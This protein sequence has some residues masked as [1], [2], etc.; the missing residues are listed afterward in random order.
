MNWNRLIDMWAEADAAGRSYSVGRSED[1]SDNLTGSLLELVDSSPTRG[2]ALY[3]EPGVSGVV[4]VVDGSKHAPPPM[5]LRSIG[6]PGGPWAVRATGLDTDT[7]TDTD[8]EETP[9][10][11]CTRLDRRS[12]CHIVELAGETGI[13]EDVGSIGRNVGHRSWRTTRGRPTPRVRTHDV[14]GGAFFPGRTDLWS[15]SS[16]TPHHNMF[17]DDYR[18]YMHWS[19]EQDRSGDCN[20]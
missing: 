12:S 5:S 10:R 18:D 15:W 17:S 16:S 19:D 2:V 3:Y 11:T 13:L 8:T 20:G 1:A 14:A 4:V 6:Y 9:A 7:D